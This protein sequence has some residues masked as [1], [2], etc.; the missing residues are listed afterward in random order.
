MVAL[1]LVAL[2]V[3]GMTACSKTKTVNGCKVKAGTNCAGKNLVKA[4][5]T[6]ANFTGASL[7]GAK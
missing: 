7:S 1:L 3:L 4:D 6:G 2:A 5:L